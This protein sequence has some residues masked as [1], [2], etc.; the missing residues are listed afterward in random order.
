M[1]KYTSKI[2]IADDSGICIHALANFPG[3]YSARFMEGHSYEE[4]NLKINEMLQDKDDKSASYHCAIAFVS[5]EE[6][7]VFVGTCE[8]VIVSPVEGPYGFGYDPIFYFEPYNK[9]FSL[10]LP[11][12]KNKV[13]HRGKATR[14]LMEYLKQKIEKNE[15]MK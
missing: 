12:D 3:V 7:K 2:V 4:K 10:T 13:S 8:G 15:K 5:D 14:L 6:E 1:G 11:D 9:T